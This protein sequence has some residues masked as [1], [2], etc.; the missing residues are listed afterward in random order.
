VNWVGPI[1]FARLPGFL[2][3]MDVGITPY[4]DSAFNRASFPLKT[5]E[6]LAAGIPAVSTDLP[7]V[8]W[9]GTDMISVA[10]AS[11]F[12]AVTRSV[13]LQ[14]DPAAVQRRI[15]FAGSHSW[16]RRADAFAQAIGISAR[17]G[18]T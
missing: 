17:S 12:G 11:N 9:L 7:A 3:A 1:E 15:A 18:E 5:L 8:R 14:N 16:V 13:A 10:Q 2:K 4:V 6:Y